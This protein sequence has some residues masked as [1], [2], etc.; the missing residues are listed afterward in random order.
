[1]K[2]QIA[3]A[4]D[5]HLLYS[6]IGAMNMDT[7]FMQIPVRKKPNMKW[8]ASLINLKMLLISAGKAMV[9]PESSSLRSTSTGLNQYRLVGL[10]Q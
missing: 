9:A 6:V 5:H 1:M 2:V 10:E 3:K 4:N 8:L 7:K